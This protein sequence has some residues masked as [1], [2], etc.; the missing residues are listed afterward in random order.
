MVV[1]VHARET[2]RDMTTSVMTSFTRQ[3]TMFRKGMGLVTLDTDGP[4]A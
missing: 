2:Q 1:R 3:R 4:T